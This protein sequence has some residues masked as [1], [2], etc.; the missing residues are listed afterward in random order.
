MSSD[1]FYPRIDTALLTPFRAL[2]GLMLSDP[3]YLSRPECP[4]TLDV[5]EFIT[6]LFSTGSVGPSVALETPED[7]E[8]ELAVSYDQLRRMGEK[9]DVI[10]AKDRIQWAKAQMG[11][12]E[13]IIALRE[14]VL[15]MRMISEFQRGVIALLDEVLEPAQ[16]TAFVERLGQ[17]LP[18][19]K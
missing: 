13:R 3:E 12:L 11:L 10:D 7:L 4:Y 16:R 2:K 9:I 8:R 19:Q 6:E 5:R 17:F 18:D 1:V 14:R 15:N